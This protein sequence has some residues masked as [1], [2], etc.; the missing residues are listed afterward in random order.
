MLQELRTAFGE[1]LGQKTHKLDDII[2][3]SSSLVSYAHHILQTTGHIMPHPCRYPVVFLSSIR[4]YSSYSPKAFVSILE[5]T[6]TL[7]RFV[8]LS[9]PLRCLSTT[10]LA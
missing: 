3:K 9:L 4:K 10:L 8:Q 6:V 7:F 1:T 5:G 2:L